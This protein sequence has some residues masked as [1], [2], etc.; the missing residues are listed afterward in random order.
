MVARLNGAYGGRARSQAYLDLAQ[1]HFL[2][3]MLTEGVFGDGVVAFKGGTALRKF[4]FGKAGR[5]S[6]DLDFWSADPIYTDHVIGWLNIGFEHQG[7]RFGSKNLEDEGEIHAEWWAE[8]DE[9]GR[10]DEPSSIEFSFRHRFVGTTVP[11]ERPPIPGVDGSMGFDPVRVPVYDLLENVAEKLARIRR[12]PKARDFYDLALIGPNMDEAHLPRIR[13]LTAW[14]VFLDFHE[15]MRI[16][17]PFRGGQYFFEIDPTSIL[18]MED[19]GR[20]AGRSMN[21]EELSEKLS[22][23][24]GRMGPPAGDLEQ[25]LS[26]CGPADY[27]WAQSQLASWDVNLT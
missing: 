6:T 9:L 21:A 13:R 26:R 7:V 17:T 1:E 16:P 14:K 5:F 11:D 12:S 15:G 3:W 10:T 18:G 27:H 22:L 25:R 4:H 23:Y 8:T 20:L 2:H 24:F 19:I